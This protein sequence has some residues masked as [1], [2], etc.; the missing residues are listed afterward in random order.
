MIFFLK[1]INKPISREKIVGW[2]GMVVHGSL[3]KLLCFLRVPCEQYPEG[4][5][6]LYHFV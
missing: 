3:P 5:R 2:V 4:K 1:Q 6:I